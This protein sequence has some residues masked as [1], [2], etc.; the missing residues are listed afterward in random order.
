MRAAKIV[1]SSSLAP[2]ADAVGRHRHCRLGIPLRETSPLGAVARV[3]SSRTNLCPLPPE[4]S[5]H[6]PGRGPSAARAFLTHAD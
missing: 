5:W 6:I 2:A 3:S 4:S 1:E